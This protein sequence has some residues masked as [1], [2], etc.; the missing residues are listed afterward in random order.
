MI[1]T[2]AIANT[3]KVMKITMSA[4]AIMLFTVV[5]FHDLMP[6]WASITVMFTVVP[7]VGT[8]V[9]YEMKQYYL[10]TLFRKRAMRG[11]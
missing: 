11:W 3:T 6:H 7:V 10:W 2:P 5:M 4:G 8:V 9:I 1:S